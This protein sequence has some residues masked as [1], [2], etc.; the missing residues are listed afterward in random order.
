[1]CTIWVHATGTHCRGDFNNQVD[2][3]ALSLDVR[4]PLC[5][6]TRGLLSGPLNKV[7]VV[8]GMQ[9]MYTL[10]NLNV[11][12]PRLPLLTLLSRERAE[13]NTESL[14]RPPFPGLLKTAV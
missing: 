3:M 7:A 14:I 12:L 6:A 10:N 4:Q 13:N 8:V 2:E 11:S 5:L 9:A 1:M